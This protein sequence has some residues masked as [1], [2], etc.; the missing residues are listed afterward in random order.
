VIFSII[1]CFSLSFCE[2]HGRRRQWHEQERRWAQEDA[3][4]AGGDMRGG[5]GQGAGGRGDGR[6]RQERSPMVGWHEA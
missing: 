3:A 1:L 2:T 6:R 5:G 4:L